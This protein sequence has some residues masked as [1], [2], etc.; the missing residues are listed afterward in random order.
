MSDLIAA[1]IRET[2]E[3]LY[4]VDIDVNGHT[5]KGDEPETYGSA[6]AC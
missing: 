1:H 2:G 4:A 6:R 5:M 3:S